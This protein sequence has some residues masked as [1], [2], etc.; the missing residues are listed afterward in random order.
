MSYLEIRYA[1]AH[2][3]SLN[4]LERKKT[5]YD[6]MQSS[7]FSH[8]DISCCIRALPVASSSRSIASVWSLRL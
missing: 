1:T 7:H 2:G 8:I 6:Y 3:D 4:G 5:K